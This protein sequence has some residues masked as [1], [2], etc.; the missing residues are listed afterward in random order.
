MVRDLNT[1][2]KGVFPFVGPELGSLDS[3]IILVRVKWILVKCE[4]EDVVT[5]FIVGV[6]LTCE[7]Q[8]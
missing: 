2:R 6:P 7:A 3:N 8:H 4:K 5:V 1:E